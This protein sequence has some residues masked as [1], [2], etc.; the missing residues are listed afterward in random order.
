MPQTFRLSALA[1]SIGDAIEMNLG[2]EPVWVTAQITDVKRQHHLRR[3]YLKMI[4]KEHGDIIADLR[5]NFWSKAYGEIED[6][7]R[8]TGQTFRDGL[9]LTA[10]VVVRFHARYGISLDVLKLQ[11]EWTLGSLERE[12]LETLERLVREHPET[13]RETEGAY[14]T[15][16]NSLLLP[17]VMRRI[18]LITAP[19]SD[20]Q[21]DFIRELDNNRYGY[22][23]TVTEFLT[24]I[25]GDD[26]HLLLVDKLEE[27]RQS[28]SGYDVV[29]IVR[30]GGSQTDFR[31]FDQYE[32]ARTV[33]EF[34]IPV[35]T[36]IGHDRN[37]SITDLMAR[38]EKTPTKVAAAIVD[39]NA[40]FE[41]RM[42]D[43]QNRFDRAMADFLQQTDNNL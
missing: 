32:L 20:G 38:Q 2:N 25:Q 29:C 39:R 24:T 13:I 14:I 15:A 10:Q 28:S 1:A 26:A 40:A 8:K 19:N 31:P 30:G 41:Q 35:F 17:P 43:L 42:E 21:R 4:E 12:R 22:R 23:F 27:I 5:A 18:A 6:F 7:E 34:P 3:C 16:N 36:G 9:E 33:A 37:T 11:I